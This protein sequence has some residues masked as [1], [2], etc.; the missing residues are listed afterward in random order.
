MPDAKVSIDILP[1][2]DYELSYHYEFKTVG[3][4]NG[5][6]DYLQVWKGHKNN[7]Y[8]YAKVWENSVN[9]VPVN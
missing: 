5:W 8:D 1:S 4:K 7:W 2:N 6:K 3:T 9:F